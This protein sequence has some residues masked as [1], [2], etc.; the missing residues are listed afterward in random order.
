LLLVHRVVVPEELPAFVIREIVNTAQGLAAEDMESLILEFSGQA[1]QT[2]LATAC[3]PG[4]KISPRGFAETVDTENIFHIVDV[5]EKVAFIRLD[6]QADG[7]SED[8]VLSL[9]SIPDEVHPLECACEIVLRV[10]RVDLVVEL[11]ALSALGDM[12]ML[13]SGK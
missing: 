2:H 7:M 11:T 6:Y 12:R 4:N 13:H 9:F 10:A 8:T 3:L 5:K 1:R